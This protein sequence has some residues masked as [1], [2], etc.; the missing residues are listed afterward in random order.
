MIG[1]STSQSRAAIYIGRTVKVYAASVRRARNSSYLLDDPGCTQ[2]N[3]VL[4]NGV[5]PIRLIL[6]V[7]ISVT[8]LFASTFSGMSGSIG[9]LRF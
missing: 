6:S 3:V 2:D 7:M 8:P 1:R 9:V 4:T 5:A